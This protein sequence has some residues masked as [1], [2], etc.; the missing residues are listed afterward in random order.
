VDLETAETISTALTELASVVP[1][2]TVK[3]T[4]RQ[5]V[6]GGLLAVRM[7]GQ[8][9]VCHYDPA[10]ADPVAWDRELRQRLGDRVTGL[11]RYVPAR[12]PPGEL[13]ALFELVVGRDWHPRAASTPLG[14]G[15]DWEREVVDVTLGAPATD[16]V[17][18]SL[19]A[20]LGDRGAVTPG[21]SLGRR[22]G[23]RR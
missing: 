9:M 1:P 5:Q 19:V 21:A 13:V 17:A 8:Q 23:S 18:T 11:V 15:V 20:L 4:V 12:T 16:E 22:R 3:P 6:A 2:G 10:L 7:D 14:A